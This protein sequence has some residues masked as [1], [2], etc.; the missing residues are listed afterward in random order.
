MDLGLEIPDISPELNLRTIRQ[1]AES[2][3]I[4]QAMIRSS[5]NVSRAAKLLGVTRPT[6]YD[7]MRKYE[8]GILP[9]E[10]KVRAGI[11]EL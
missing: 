2:E 1:R 3:A 8:L 11:R 10:M 7:M 4:Q 6:L 5:N 9:H